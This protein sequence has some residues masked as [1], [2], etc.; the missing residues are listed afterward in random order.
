MT[1][2]ILSSFFLQSWLSASSVLSLSP[3][4]LKPFPRCIGPAPRVSWVV[5]R[6]VQ[7]PHCDDLWV[8][9]TVPTAQPYSLDW[10]G[11]GTHGRRMSWPTFSLETTL[12]PSHDKTQWLPGHHVETS[13][14]RFST[15][16][17][18]RVEEVTHRAS[19]TPL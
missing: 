5:R 16:S 3:S 1:T 7:H 18:P 2:T 13:V 11:E 4:D 19:V 15:I 17:A 12:T 14:S 6:D 9:V 10:R 8:V